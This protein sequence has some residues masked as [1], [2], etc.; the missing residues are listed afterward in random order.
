MVIYV[1]VKFEFD[2]TKC[3][4]VRVRKQKNVDGQ[5]D[6]GH[7]NLIGWLVTH[8]QMKKKSQNF[9]LVLFL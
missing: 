3:F 7:I 1:P 2:W 5:T 4:W 8:E 9:E 6:V